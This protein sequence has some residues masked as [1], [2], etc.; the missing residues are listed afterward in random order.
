MAA[1][2]LLVHV[3][4]V[5]IFIQAR[6]NAPVDTSL[7]EPIVAMFLDQPRGVPPGSAPMAADPPPTVP[8]ISWAPPVLEIVLTEEPEP[9]LADQ[10]APQ[11]EPNTASSSASEATGSGS[12]NDGLSGGG[13]GLVVVER[14]LPRY[15]ERSMRL[16]E[17][18]TVVL[19]V[20]VNEKGRVA[21]VK[22]AR[23]S[24]YQRLDSA[25]MAAIRRW[26]FIP[27]ARDSRPVSSWGETELRFILYPF[28]F[29]RVSEQWMDR[30]PDEQVKAG[31]TEVA[32]GGGD[33]GLRRFIQDFSG[34]GL[35]DA[36]TRDPGSDTAK[37]R[38]ALNEWGPVQ[39]VE[40]KA[41]Y[42]DHQWRPYGIK[43][44][45]R[46][47][48]TGN[49]VDLRWDVYEV[50]HE[51]GTSLWRVGLDRNGTVWVAQ[52]RPVNAMP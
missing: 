14:I 31:V 46:T 44:Q 15:P 42:G 10:D 41:A 34:A 27:A 37:F 50:R 32:T 47:G 8:Q 22:L 2:V 49:T 35:V 23:G 48:T 19:Q 13:H 25:A 18:G 51:R 28:V 3:A 33:V 24:G 38:A 9:P 1:L 30:A 26:K 20:Q 12:A 43:P 39:A 40:F 5:W 52:A 36:S 4:L 17:E 21:D 29:S 7:V 16:G 45:Y 11:L 6:V